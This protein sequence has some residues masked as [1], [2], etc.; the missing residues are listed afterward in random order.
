MHAHTQ[1][2]VVRHKHETF[3]PSDDDDEDDAEYPDKLID[4]FMAET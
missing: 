4:H 1:N 3:S 2:I